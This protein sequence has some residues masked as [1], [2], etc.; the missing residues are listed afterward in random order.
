MND[1]LGRIDA[2]KMAQKENQTKLR[3]RTNRL[4]EQKKAIEEL[5]NDI[6]D[7]EVRV[8]NMEE[9][10]DEAIKTTMDNPRGEMVAGRQKNKKVMEKKTK[11]IEDILSA[12]TKR[13]LEEFQKMNMQTRKR[14]EDRENS[15]DP[16]LR[17]PVTN[18]YASQDWR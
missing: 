18:K 4:S 8:E 12:G 14:E 7:L 3:L 9:G 2:L 13:M 5:Y 11:E 17:A 1:V 10:L 16:T 15:G 6:A